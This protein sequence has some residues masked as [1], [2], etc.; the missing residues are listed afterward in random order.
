MTV[1]TSRPWR[2]ALW[3]WLGMVIFTVVWVAGGLFVGNGKIDSDIDPGFAGLP[4]ALMISVMITLPAGLV[5]F[6]MLPALSL[7]FASAQRRLRFVWARVLVGIALC[8]PLFVAYVIATKLPQV[9]GWLGPKRSTL[10]Q[11]FAAIAH[12]PKQAIPF[13]VLFAIAGVIFMLRQYTNNPIARPN[14]QIP[15]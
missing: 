12:R 9:L 6:V 4:D 14:N 5:A 10:A 13:L 15:S 1:N 3:A 11:D 8:L 2:S 7:A